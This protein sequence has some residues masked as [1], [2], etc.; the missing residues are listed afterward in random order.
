MKI[1]EGALNFIKEQAAQYKEPVVV[2]FQ[3]TYRG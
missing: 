2:M 1:S 3:R